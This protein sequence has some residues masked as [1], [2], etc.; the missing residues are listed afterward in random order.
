MVKFVN[1]V[2]LLEVLK[3]GEKMVMQK[4]EQV[5][6]LKDIIVD[7]NRG[8]LDFENI[9]QILLDAGAGGYYSRI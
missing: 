8:A 9:D 6:R 5:E 3:N 7:Y 2:S 4:P 1:C